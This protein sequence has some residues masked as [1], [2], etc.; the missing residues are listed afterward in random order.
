MRQ[1]LV[2]CSKLFQN[3]TNIR[4]QYFRSFWKMCVLER[5]SVLTFENNK[6]QI[7]NGVH[8]AKNQS[9]PKYAV[10]SHQHG[11]AGWSDSSLGTLVIL[12]FHFLV[13]CKPRRENL[14]LEL[15]DQVRLDAACS[16]TK[17]TNINQLY[18]IRS[19]TTKIN[20]PC[21]LSL[22]FANI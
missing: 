5:P 20:L 9:T 13:L 6:L 7:L 15:C 10:W 18:M 3:V 22:A 2:S 4:C 19:C 8:T 21:Y 1:S 14:S 12:Y 11:C 16:A 17:L